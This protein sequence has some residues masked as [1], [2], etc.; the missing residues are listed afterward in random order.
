[1]SDSHTRQ[2]KV[3]SVGDSLIHGV[4]V[5]GD[6]LGVGLEMTGT[7]VRK[8]IDGTRRLLY[9]LVRPSNTSKK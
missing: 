2:G 5:A 7:A 3:H 9:G 8:G 1:M 4:E 6:V